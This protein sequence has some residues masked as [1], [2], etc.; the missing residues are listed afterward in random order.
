V[1]VAAIYDIHG[2]LPALEAVMA[3]I[4]R[5]S[6]D[7]IVVGG[8]VLPGPMP[9]ET[10]AY[11]FAL[12]IPVQFISG[13]GDR[14]VLEQRAGKESA[15]V[16]EQF[17]DIIRWNAQ[18][19]RPE[20][21]HLIAT[22]PQTLRLDIDGLGPVFFCHA[23]PQNDR[24]I[25]TRLTPEERLVPVFAGVN[26]AIAVC[27][28]THIQFDRNVGTM[29]VVNA[30]SVGMPFQAPGAYWMMLGPDLQLRKTAYDLAGAADRIRRTKYPQAEDFASNN[31]LNP[32][33][34]QQMLEAYAR[35]SGV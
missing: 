25:F 31:V 7:R 8:D 11:L 13:N 3:E 12:D 28:H 14:V 27:G 23:V 30:G 21:E 33:T 9:R 18:Q 5:A 19:L 20:D 4:R 17:R 1:R 29:R 6:V 35:V 26:A 10:L 16:P 15:E 22:W 2:N 32:P 24:D 34:E